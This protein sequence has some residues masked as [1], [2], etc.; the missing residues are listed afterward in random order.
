MT[1]Y[2]YVSVIMPFDNE[3]KFS[4][5]LKGHHCIRAMIMGME[6]VSRSFNVE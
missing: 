1:D 3:P 5:G 4:G 2:V 6:Q